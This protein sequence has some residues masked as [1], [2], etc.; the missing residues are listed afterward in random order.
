MWA[1]LSRANMQR[2]LDINEV[3]T[4]LRDEKLEQ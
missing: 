2:Q 4:Q 1:K 3:Q